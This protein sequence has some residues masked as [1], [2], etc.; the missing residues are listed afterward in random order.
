MI[1]PP[2]AFFSLVLFVI[3][4]SSFFIFPL[5]L[6]SACS[7]KP[8]PTPA[9]ANPSATNVQTF[10]VKGVIKGLHTDNKTVDIRHEAITNFMPAMTM[11]FDVKDPKE[12]TGLK[13]NDPVTFRLSVT[14][15]ESWIDQI[16]K[17]DAL[18]L[19]SSSPSSSTLSPTSSPSLTDLPATN[20]FRF[21]RDAEP[22]Q[23]GDPLPEYH[24]TNQFGQAVSTSQFKG[25]AFAISF[26][27]TRCPLPNFCPRMSS[28]FEEAQTKLL[29]DKAGPTNWHLITISF[30]PEFD[31]PAI[32]KA[33]ADRFHADPAHWT[34][35]TGALADV[36]AISEQFGQTFYKDETGAIN[37]NLRTVVVTSSGRIHQI[38]T[39]NKYTS[40]ELA[41]SLLQAAKQ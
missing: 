17:L 22:L 4:H 15:T 33:Y 39:G 26:I 32:L 6:L 41:A 19:L 8:S 23:I 28:N 18:S 35:L 37:H 16:R 3:R 20:G 2:A 13:T 12:L 9:S 38:I 24:F 14:D 1:R 34:F 40:D 31:T 7:D 10:Q 5:F 30:D 27:F 21:V 29:A 11:P 25:Q 36:T